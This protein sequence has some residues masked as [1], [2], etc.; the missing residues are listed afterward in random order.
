MRTFDLS[1]MG[2]EEDGRGGR[3]KCCAN[4][5][6]CESHTVTTASAYYCSA[7]RKY[8]DPRGCCPLYAP[9]IGYSTAMDEVGE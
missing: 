5:I 1:E 6:R 2:K 9:K 8:I 7:Y 4:C 3:M